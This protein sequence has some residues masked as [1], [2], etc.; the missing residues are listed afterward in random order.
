MD[1]KTGIT[2]TTR[3]R[4]LRA[5]QNSMELVRDFQSYSKEAEDEERITKMFSE[6]AEDEALHSATLLE[7]LHDYERERRAAQTS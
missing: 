1:D 5:W 4:L 3:D 7:M 6:F 2:I